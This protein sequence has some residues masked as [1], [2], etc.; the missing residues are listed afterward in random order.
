VTPD[1]RE[2]WLSQDGKDLRVRVVEPASA[3]LTVMDAQPLPS[4]PKPE[5]QNANTGVRKLAI[6]LTNVVDLSLE[7]VFEPG[8]TIAEAASGGN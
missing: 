2:A 7:V 5:K 8:P 6:Q 4:S 3:R 1:G